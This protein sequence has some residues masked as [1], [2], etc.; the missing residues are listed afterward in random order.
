MFVTDN[1]LELNGV[2]TNEDEETDDEE[3]DLDEEEVDL[4]DSDDDSD[5]GE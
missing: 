2:F 3:M 4:D 1:E 5:L